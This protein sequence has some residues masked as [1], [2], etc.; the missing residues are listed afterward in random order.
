MT[1][2]AAAALPLA[3]VRV[4]EVGSVLMVPYAGQI[5]GDLGADVVKVESLIGDP[6][7]LAGPGT[8]PE[9]SGIALNINR[10]KRSI[11]VDLASPSGKQVLHRLVSTSDV[12]LTNLRPTALEKLD[13]RYA[14][15]AQ[16]RPDIV[17]CRSHGHASDSPDAERP[18][19]DDIVQ[20]ASGIAALSESI[21]GRPR[22]LPTVLA[23]KVSGLTIVYAVLAALL[24]RRSTGVGQEVEVPMFDT[25]LSFILVEHLAGA[26]P[27]PPLTQPGYRRVLTPHRRPLRTRDGWVVTMPYSTRDWRRLWTRLGE[28]EQL[29]AL[30]GL[31]EAEVKARAPEFYQALGSA[32][33]AATSREWVA[34]CAEVDVAASEVPSLAELVEQ[35]ALHRGVLSTRHHDVCGDYLSIAPPVRF[36][37]SHPVL[38]DAPRIGE[39]TVELLREA[40]FTDDEVRVMVSA[41]TVKAA[42]D[43]TAAA[44]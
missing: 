6:N 23:D 19:Y 41:G 34:L 24:Q 13:L 40:G 5:L 2:A 1:A 39:Q 8:H 17:Y 33:A 3:G 25:M 9:L 28:V 22:L 29:A 7:R 26:T 43:P 35:P 16:S 11:A 42:L 36:S 15:V 21:D 14:D 44:S 10:N 30:E 38:R 27:R 12:L 18:A 31:T 20:A 4:L 37:S 32:V